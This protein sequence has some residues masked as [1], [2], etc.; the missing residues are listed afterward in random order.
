LSPALIF[1]FIDITKLEAVY[2]MVVMCH[3]F[4]DIAF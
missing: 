4:S 3:L 2:D 1:V